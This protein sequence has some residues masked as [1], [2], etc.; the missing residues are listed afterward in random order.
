MLPT[1][2]ALFILMPVISGFAVWNAVAEDSGGG[3]EAAIRP[4]VVLWIALIVI[5]LAVDGSRI[6]GRS[7]EWDEVVPMSATAF[8]R[9]AAGDFAEVG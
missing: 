1:T 6:S 8:E 9:L 5:G 2:T 7:G 3:W 4:F